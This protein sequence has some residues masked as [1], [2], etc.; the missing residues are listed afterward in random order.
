MLQCSTTAKAP[1]AAHSVRRPSAVV[2]VMTAEAATSRRRVPCGRRTSFWPTRRQ[3]PACRAPRTGGSHRERSPARTRQT[4]SPSAPAQCDDIRVARSDDQQGRRE[5][6][7]QR[8]SGEIRPAAPR[9]DGGDGHA[10]IGC[11]RHGGAAAGAGAEVPDG[12]RARVVASGQPAGRPDQTLGQQVDVED[13]GSI[14]LLG[15][16]QQIEQQCGQTRVI[17]YLCDITIPGAAAAA[18]TPVGEHDD[19]HGPVG[20]GEVSGHSCSRGRH[21]DILARDLCTRHSTTVITKQPRE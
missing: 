5:N 16:C 15:R 11:R 7:R 3:P 10:G 4:T 19:P 14:L 13:V 17:E 12:Q 18:S 9:Y 20:H 21:R 8:R 2:D 1:C 6:S